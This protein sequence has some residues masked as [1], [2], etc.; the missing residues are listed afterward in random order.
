DTVYRGPR[1]M[2]TE[3]YS[4]I[5]E[6]PFIRVHDDPRS[7]FAMDVDTASYANVRRFLNENLLPPPDAVRIEELVN[8]FKY[9]YEPPAGKDPITIYPEVTSPFWAPRHRLVKIAL[10]SKDVDLSSRKR[11]NLVFLVDVSG[12]M[13][14]PVKLPLV[15]RSLQLLV[16]Q[17]RDDD[18]ISMV[19]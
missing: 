10:R 11:A 8:Y 9:H 5:D 7:T 16:D 18:Q 17:L 1:R 15:K 4:H 13:M 2:N 14:E 6:N 12:S 3:S 19:V